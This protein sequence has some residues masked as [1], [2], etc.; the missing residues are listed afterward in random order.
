MATANLWINSEVWALLEPPNGKWV[1]GKV[2]SF[3]SSSRSED[4]SHQFTFEVA[5]DDETIHKLSTIAADKDN[6]EFEWVKMRSSQNLSGLSDMTSLSHLNEP[7]MIEMLRYRYSQGEIYTSI[8]PILVAINPFQ[9]LPIYGPA[10]LDSYFMGATDPHVYRL[11]N[12]AYHR[13]FIDK[14]DPDKREN[15]AILVN[16]ESGAGM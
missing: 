12:N 10:E 7:E 16:G 1:A 4:S 13:M 6:L 2:I 5:T 3:S 11:A 9:E 15:Q 8:G 14:F